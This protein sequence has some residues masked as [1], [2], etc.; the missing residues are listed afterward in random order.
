MFTFPNIN[1]LTCY[2]CMCLQ[3]GYCN[4]CTNVQKANIFMK[5]ITVYIWQICVSSP[6]YADDLTINAINAKALQ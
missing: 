5:I 3:K 1:V 2:D 6:A 4:R